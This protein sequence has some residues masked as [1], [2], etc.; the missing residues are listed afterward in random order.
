MTKKILGLDL[1]IT[2]IGWALVE[3]AENNSEESKIIKLGVRVT[4]LTV[5]EKPTLKKDALQ[6]LILKE[7]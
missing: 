6:V 4:P 2:S 1:G 7:P 5:D 3:E